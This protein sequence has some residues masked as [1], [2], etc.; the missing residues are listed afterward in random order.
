MLNYGYIPKLDMYIVITSNVIF[1]RFDCEG[2]A[3]YLLKIS[4]DKLY[5]YNEKIPH[6]IWTLTCNWQRYL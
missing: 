2:D 4:L 6:N 1:L 3:H 5:P